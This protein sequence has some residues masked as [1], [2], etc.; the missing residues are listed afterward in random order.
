MKQ[1]TL[2][3]GT[4]RYRE[5]G[6]GPTVVFV[7]GF[8]VDHSL[9]DGA[10]AEL[11]TTHRCIVPD[12]PMGSHHLPMNP[13]ADLSPSG[14]ARIVADFLAEL[15]LRDV[16]LVGNDSGGAICQ[17][18]AANHPLRIGRVVLT[19]CDAY[20][21]FPPRLFGYLKWL[22]RIPGAIFAMARLMRAFT[23]VMRTPIA[24]GWAA[25]KRIASETL[26]A[27]V[28]PLA[29]SARIR[30][31]VKKFA[32]G[33][34]PRFTLEAA[35]VL[36]SSSIP[37]LLVWAAEKTF[38][39]L[40]LAER[41]ARELPDAKLVLVAGA[42]AFLPMDQPERLADE[43]SRYSSQAQPGSVRQ[44]NSNEMHVSPHA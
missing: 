39:P 41:L 26:R 34:D 27:W 15:D 40:R 31:D 9:W 18:T 7:H 28:T 1:V 4:I 2:S 24:Y 5:I 3:Q 23:P 33:L 42:G 36:R 35:E 14:M 22:V 32:L 10:V 25:K 30:R 20:E 29:H 8:L 21:V 13:D 37:V 12:W 43:I 6:L 11:S 17:I 44:E 38:F 16:T 19:P